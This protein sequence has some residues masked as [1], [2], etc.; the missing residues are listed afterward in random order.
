M[1][2]KALSA[3][4]DRLQLSSVTERISKESIAGGP[5][6][7]Y[8]FAG[9]LLLVIALQFVTGVVL[10]LHY[11]PSAT[12]AW[13]SVFFIETQVVAGSLI[14]GLHHHGASI[15]VVLVVAHLLQVIF[16]RAYRK[17]REVTWFLGL[18]L[19]LLLFAFALTGY[20][21]PWDERGYG[22]TRVATG[23]ISLT[24][25]IGE[26]LR[27]V[28]LG[29][30]GYGHLTLTRFYAIH[31]IVLPLCLITVL[32]L[33][34]Y[35]RSRHGL[36]GPAEKPD[37][38]MA[39]APYWP[40]QVFRTFLF[41]CIVFAIM[42]AMASLHP[43]PLTAP[44]DPATSYPA[45]PEWYF[46]SLFQLLKTDIFTGPR[47]VLGSHGLPTLLLFGLMILPFF[48]KDGSPGWRRKLILGSVAVVLLSVFGLSMAALSD[49]ASDE[50]FK[51]EL[52]LGDERA[53]VAKELAK[54]GIPP[55]GALVMMRRSVWNG[56]KIYQ[57]RCLECHKGEKR[58]GPE[59]EGYLTVE[60]VA[61]LI[62]NPSHPRFYGK[63]KLGKEGAM[64]GYSLKQSSREALAKFLL[65][66]GTEK[67]RAKGERLFNKKGCADC[68][69]LNP[70]LPCE[71]PNLHEYG[72]PAWIRLTVENPKS[73]LRYG[74]LSTMPAFRDELSDDEMDA[75]VGYLMTL[76]KKAKK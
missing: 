22:A 13:E 74:T 27:R 17:P 36:K 40:G 29:G 71:G 50:Q 5:R 45:R 8:V 1:L 37:Q 12:S 43:A 56:E 39:S 15:I 30:K 34:L 10:A 73:F 26:S 55:E 11:S 58:E 21:L 42:L 67:E 20:L 53:R 18:G 3:I 35:A 32:G 6:F 41:T 16:Y 65:K 49:D 7:A 61:E 68:H 63:S 66:L 33:H 44:A 52:I 47:E 4:H 46:L 9:A 54:E 62:K 59:L 75:V 57:Q 51:N 48:D 24:P 38:P 2:R 72:S 23:L 28:A 25:G 64:E 76:R 69:E 14:R 70:E 31:I 60:W 19:L